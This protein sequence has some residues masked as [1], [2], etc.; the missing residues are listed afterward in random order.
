M[1]IK[2]TT[3][4]IILMILTL[5]FFVSQDVQESMPEV[6]FLHNQLL[7]TV[8]SLQKELTAYKERELIFL[9][10]I[11][12]E[13]YITTAY[14]SIDSTEKRYSGLTATGVVAEPYFTV[15]VDPK[16][17]PINTWIWIDSL[18]WWKAQDTGNTIRGRKIDLCLST[19]KGAFEFGVRKMR[20]KILK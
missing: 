15:A 19:R 16:V 20:I 14:L 12:R 13:E 4:A 1:K 8:D 18:G 2:R 17:V 10:H 5:F 11:G 7:E 3:G 6:N 9:R